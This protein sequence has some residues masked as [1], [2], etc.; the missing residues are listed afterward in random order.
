MDMPPTLSSKQ[1]LSC[2]LASV[3]ENAN[4]LQANEPTTSEDEMGV[5]RVRRTSNPN[6]ICD[7]VQAARAER[8]TVEGQTTQAGGRGEGEAPGWHGA[9][10]DGT[11]AAAAEATP[12]RPSSVPGRA[13]AAKDQWAVTNRRNKSRKKRIGKTRGRRRAAGRSVE[14][15]ERDGDLESAGEQGR[16]QAGGGG[17]HFE[18]RGRK[19]W[20]E[21]KKGGQGKGRKKRVRM[22]GK[23]R[24]RRM[25]RREKRVKRGGKGRRG[26][27]KGLEEEKKR[28]RRREGVRRTS[29]RRR[30]RRLGGGRGATAR[31]RE[32]R[33]RGVTRSV[34]RGVPVPPP[35]PCLPTVS[36][37][38]AQI[39]ARNRI[40][41]SRGEDTRHL[42][43]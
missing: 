24:R 21:R 25:K 28:K 9:E 40:S 11:A 27:R 8:A 13:V 37:T 43:R 14:S 3:S 15:A 30:R 32:G 26:R 29:R 36:T 7:A 35:T 39:S 33:G 38:L 1:N 16:A 6:C 19:M 42:P 5:G 41:P 34:A 12:K 17:K 18:G 31:G 20:K 2:R 4:G 23:G 22:R 10:R